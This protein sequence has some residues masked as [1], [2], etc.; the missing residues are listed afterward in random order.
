MD[1][2]R[3]GKRDWAKSRWKEISLMTAGDDPW[4]M[5]E[6]GWVMGY[7]L[8]VL[9]VGCWRMISM[10]GGTIDN[11]WWVLFMGKG[12]TT[13]L[14]LLERPLRSNSKITHWRTWGLMIL[15]Y[16][17]AIC[18]PLLLLVVQYWTSFVGWL[19]VVVHSWNRFRHSKLG[20]GWLTQKSYVWTLDIWT[21]H[22]RVCL[23]GFLE[24]SKATLGRKWDFRYRP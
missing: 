21:W 9:G 18:F 4:L 17:K 1:W 7:G 14:S 20:K 10:S 23:E 24:T 5:P 16:E 2:K 22:L 15:H 6:R 8:W 11:R 13:Y 3:T 19:L 12:T